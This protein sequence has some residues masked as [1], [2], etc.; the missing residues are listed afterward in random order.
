MNLHC[1]LRDSHSATRLRLELVE[2]KRRLGAELEK[3]SAD[4]EKQK[5][6]MDQMKQ[7]RATYHF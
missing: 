5:A 4:L 7:V 3:Q 1:Q 2:E 6:R